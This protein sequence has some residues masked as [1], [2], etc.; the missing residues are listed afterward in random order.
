[1]AVFASGTRTFFA[2]MNA[3]TGWTRDFSTYNEYTLRVINGATAGVGGS[4]DFTSTFASRSVTG[5]APF[6]GFSA[7]STTLGPT[8]LPAHQH[9]GPGGV[10]L[11][12]SLTSN[13][14]PAS[15]PM[16]STTPVLTN[17]GANGTAG[18][19]THPFST[20]GVNVNGTLNISVQYV[21]II[22]ATK[23]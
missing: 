15:F 21:D 14:S 5:T 9:F 17:T 20:L 12:Y 8:N 18:G 4:I 2:N 23:N 7:G 3:P 22:V 13:S 10:T 16:V 19:H 11:S 6:S 1:M